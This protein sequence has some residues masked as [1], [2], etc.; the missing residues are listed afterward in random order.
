MFP[1]E[2]CWNE[3]NFC[4]RTHFQLQPTYP[5]H[6][7]NL[8]FMIKMANLH[9]DLPHVPSNCQQLF[10]QAKEV[11]NKFARDLERKTVSPQLY[12][13]V[14]LKLYGAKL[15]VTF[16]SPEYC[17]C[18]DKLC[19]EGKYLLQDTILYVKNDLDLQHLRSF[20]QAQF[21]VWKEKCHY[22]KSDNSDTD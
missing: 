6:F 9:M 10:Q 12:F 20:L 1:L 14:S 5:T 7:W 15:R 3:W 19:K 13:K 21:N 11:V 4:C 16:Y 8:W 17:H 22:L 18:S 2:S